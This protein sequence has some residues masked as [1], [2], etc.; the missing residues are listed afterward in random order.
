M[1]RVHVQISIVTRKWATILKAAVLWVTH[2]PTFHTWKVI[3]SFQAYLPY[4]T[5]G[6]ADFRLVANI[7]QSPVTIQRISSWLREKILL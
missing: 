7:L 2:K 3:P 4:Y 1:W 5:D 6:K